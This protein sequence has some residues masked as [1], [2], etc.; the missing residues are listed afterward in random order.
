MPQ[1]IVARKDTGIEVICQRIVARKDTEIEAMPQRIVARSRQ[2]KLR[3]LG[4]E[5]NL[6]K[7]IDVVQWVRA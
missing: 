5:G 6:M 4:I 1:R 2:A 3:M 7:F